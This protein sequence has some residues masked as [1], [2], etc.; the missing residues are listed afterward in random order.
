MSTSTTVEADKWVLPA[1]FT[2]LSLRYDGRL[3]ASSLSIPFDAS[4]SLL[5]FNASR[6][7]DIISS[8]AMKDTD[9]NYRDRILLSCL[10]Q[11]TH[12]LYKPGWPQ[13]YKGQFSVFVEPLDIGEFLFNFG[14]TDLSALDDHYVRHIRRKYQEINPCY[15]MID[16]LAPKIGNKYSSEYLSFNQVDEAIENAAQIYAS[17]DDDKYVVYFTRAGEYVRCIGHEQ[18]RYQLISYD[19]A[20]SQYSDK[21]SSYNVFRFFGAKLAAPKNNGEDNSWNLPSP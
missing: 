19:E 1:Y 16:I 18:D 6:I 3:V 15:R 21:I 12:L 5:V 9:R 10:A 4:L 14:V 20:H 7:R 8:A 11:E 2:P 17:D 13:G